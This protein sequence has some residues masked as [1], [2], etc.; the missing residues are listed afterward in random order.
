ME[1]ELCDGRSGFMNMQAMK[2]DPRSVYIFA[3]NNLGT[4]IKLGRRLLLKNDVFSN[5]KTNLYTTN[6]FYDDMLYIK[7]CLIAIL[8]GNEIPVYTGKNFKRLLRSISCLKFQELYDKLKDKEYTS[9][10]DNTSLTIEPYYLT[11]FRKSCIDYSLRDIFVSIIN[12]VSYHIDKTKFQC[13][14]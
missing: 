9:Y 6:I 12:K 14:R 1:E 2:N 8:M 5:T 11:K 13:G 10:Q 7:Q 4:V 3:D